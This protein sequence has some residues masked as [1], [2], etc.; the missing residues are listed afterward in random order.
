MEKKV[1]PGFGAG[2]FFAEIK[3]AAA[4]RRAGRVESSGCNRFR[5]T[6]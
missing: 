3:S 6:A 1:I 4:W 5:S 2:T